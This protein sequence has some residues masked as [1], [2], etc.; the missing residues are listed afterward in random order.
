MS[1]FNRFFEDLSVA[2]KL[3][4]SCK[5]IVKLTKNKT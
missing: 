1:D 5:G 4:L 2:T 3:L